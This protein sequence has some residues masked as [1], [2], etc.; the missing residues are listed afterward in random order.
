MW[1]F[2]ASCASSRLLD[3]ILEVRAGILH[4]VVEEELIEPPVEVV[5]VVDVLARTARRVDLVQP[6]DESAIAGAEAEP[7]RRR[8]ALDIGLSQIQEVVDRPD[9]HDHAAVHVVLAELQVGVKHDLPL[10]G[11]LGKADAHEFAGVIAEAMG[12]TIGI[13]DLKRPLGNH[14]LQECVQQSVHRD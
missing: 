12:L 9:L 13:D 3:A 7:P 14:P 8:Q 1:R 11:C 2:F 5:V 6:A 4:V 10:G